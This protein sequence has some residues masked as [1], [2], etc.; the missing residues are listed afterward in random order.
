MKQSA[1]MSARIAF[2]V[3]GFLMLGTL[4]FTLLTD[5]SPFRK[6]LLTPWMVATL[7]DFY[8]NV[9]A[10]SVWVAY[11]ESSLISGFLWILL[12][13]CFGSIT[14]CAYVVKQLVQ[15]TSQDPVYLIL[16]NRGNRAENRYER[17]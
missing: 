8:I 12:L 2:S 9:V 13:I 16:F 14:T 1:V 17:T 11:K 3:L 5:G 15:L 10:L 7:I 6:E 4:I